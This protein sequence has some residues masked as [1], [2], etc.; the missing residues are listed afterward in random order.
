M[1]IT[2]F[3]N[4]A[5]S[6]SQFIESRMSGVSLKSPLFYLQDPPNALLISRDFTNLDVHDSV[7]G[8]A[9][10]VPFTSFR[11][12]IKPNEQDARSAG[13][14]RMWCEVDNDGCMRALIKVTLHNVNT[15]EFTFV[16]VFRAGGK[17]YEV[18]VWLKGKRLTADVFDLFPGIRNAAQGLA[19]SFLWFL[20]EIMSPAN[21]VATVVPRKHG[22]TVA[23]LKARTHYVLI[24]KSHPA[25]AKN[26]PTDDV[27]VG[28][29]Y[30]LR[31][32]HSRRA[33]VRILKSARYRNRI[34]QRILVRSCWVGPKEWGDGVSIYKIVD[35][36]PVTVR[37]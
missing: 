5:P 11:L 31:Q 16:T 12:C 9:A 17:R 28:P 19:L 10:G 22:K 2:T 35:S 15:R 26:S 6:A 4:D 23:W 3:N 8:A 36:V 18:G 24:H 13:E 37:K 33:H 29:G 27:Q 30:V 1:N 7:V 34:G 14:S 20:S 25:N 32:A 21:F